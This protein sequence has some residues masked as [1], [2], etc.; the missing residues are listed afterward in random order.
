[1]QMKLDNLLPYGMQMELDEQL[2]PKRIADV[3]LCGNGLTF[4]DCC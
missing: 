4:E 2:S 1:M 3:G